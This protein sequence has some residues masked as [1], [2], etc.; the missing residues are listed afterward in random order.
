M[1]GNNIVGIVKVTKKKVD[2]P[3]VAS[4]RKKKKDAFKLFG[5]EYR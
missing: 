2:K 3:F 1:E 5:L 4:A